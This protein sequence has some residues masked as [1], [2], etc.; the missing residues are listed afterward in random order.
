MLAQV[1]VN[2]FPMHTERFRTVQ[3][4][5]Q[6]AADTQLLNVDREVRRARVWTAGKVDLQT[7][8]EVSERT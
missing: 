6:G 4:T 3:A 2:D 1:P 5:S 8:D 7:R